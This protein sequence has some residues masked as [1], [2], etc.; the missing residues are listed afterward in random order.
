MRPSDFPESNI[1]FNAPAGEEDRVAPLR[2]W[3]G[4]GDVVELWRPSFR[5]RLSMLLFGRL[6][7]HML[8]Q[9]PPPMALTCKRRYFE[10]L[11]EGGDD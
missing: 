8:G 10:A 2:A 6:W 9:R 3:I 5:E 1:T 7:I 4:N 11:K